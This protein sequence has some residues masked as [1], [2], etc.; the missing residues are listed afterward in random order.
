[1]KRASEEKGKTFI[2]G[3]VFSGPAFMLRRAEKE[4][5]V[6]SGISFKPHGAE[7]ILHFYWLTP[8]ATHTNGSIPVDIRP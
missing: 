3:F 7:E 1:M 5:F 8:K 6:D 2:N 4:N